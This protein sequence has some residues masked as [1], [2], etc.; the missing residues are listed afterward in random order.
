MPD[1]KSRKKVLLIEDDRPAGFALV[2]ALE[3]H[4][5]Q[6]VHVRRGE[7]AL[8]V[9]S[10]EKPDVILLDLKLAGTLEGLPLLG[11]FRAHP[12]LRAIPV[13][14]VTNFGLPQDI[15]KGLAA[16]AVEYLLKSDH[17]VQE[18]VAKTESYADRS[19]IDGAR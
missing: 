5:L 11:Q 12:Q 9:A 10:L 8:E 1:M 13:L 2:R 18:I 7:E 17:A 15:E 19:T 4:G 14:I 3:K 16:G 6:V